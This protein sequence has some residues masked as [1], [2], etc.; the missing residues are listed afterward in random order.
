MSEERNDNRTQQADSW[1]GLI[2]RLILSAIVIAIAAFLTPG[3]SI[4]SIW[5]VLLAAVIISVVDYLIQRMTD[6]QAS[7]FGRGF[8]G[9][10]ISA[11]VLYGTQF[12]VPT[13]RV[14]IWGALIGALVIGIIDVIIP[15]KTF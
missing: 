9:F 5:A 3:F 2:L 14:S 8:S 4:N 12:L 6:F 11:I 15:G 10:I 1:V 7:P 13:M